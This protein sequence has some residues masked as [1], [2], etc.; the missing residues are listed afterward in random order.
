MLGQKAITI[1]Y[2]SMKNY[3]LDLYLSVRPTES[4]ETKGLA[5]IQVATADETNLQNEFDSRGGSAHPLRATGL[6][7]D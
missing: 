6:G 3:K 2:V 5:F 7:F 4:A 1:F